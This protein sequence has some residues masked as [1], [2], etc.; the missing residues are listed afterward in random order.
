MRYDECCDAMLFFLRRHVDSSH[1]ARC[2][3]V[4]VTIAT[5]C[6]DSDAYGARSV[7]DATRPPTMLDVAMM[8]RA[9]ERVIDTPSILFALRRH[10]IY[11]IVIARKDDTR[12]YTP[13]RY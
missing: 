2:Y 12:C 6:R 11:T 4:H 3:A 10:K 1:G 9:V 5:L 8:L 13:L 7:D